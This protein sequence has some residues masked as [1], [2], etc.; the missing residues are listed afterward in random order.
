MYRAD[1]VTDTAFHRA[2]AFLG[3]FDRNLDITQVVQCV[4]YSENFDSYIEGFFDKPFDD[5]VGVMPV[6]HTVLPAQ[7]H[8]ERCIGYFLFEL[9]SPFPGVLV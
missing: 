4:K 5:V 9:P 3:G 1:G 2:A 8:L 6:A 7:K